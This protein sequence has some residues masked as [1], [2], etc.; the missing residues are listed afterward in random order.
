MLDLVRELPAASSDV[1]DNIIVLWKSPLLQKGIPHHNVFS[2]EREFRSL[3][4][5]RLHL[6]ELVEAS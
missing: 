3:C 5:A 6:L 2:T 4:G 1:D